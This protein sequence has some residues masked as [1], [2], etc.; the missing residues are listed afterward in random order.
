MFYNLTFIKRKKKR[1][2]CMWCDEWI[3]VG[4][5]AVHVAGNEEDMWHG[6]LH[7]EC[8]DATRRWSAMPEN[9]H[10]REWPT[11]DGP[12]VRG[13]HHDPEG[14]MRDVT[15]RE[16][17]MS[18][19]TV[20]LHLA[21]CGHVREVAKSH[22]LANRTEVR[23]LECEAAARK[24]LKPLARTMHHHESQKF[25]SLKKHV[26]TCRVKGGF[27]IG[28]SIYPYLCFSTSD[29]GAIDWNSLKFSNTPT[30]NMLILRWDG[31]VFNTYMP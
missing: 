7:P 18:P 13:L 26:M 1:R 31:I 28:D 8:Y 29:T 24:E 3:E 22:V 11:E 2:R 6:V 4:S 20:V 9:S 23:C 19:E 21:V 16:P 5:P 15:S 12:R 27:S 10:R 17:G 25:G 14:Y 30:D